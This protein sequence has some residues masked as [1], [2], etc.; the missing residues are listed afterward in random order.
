MHSNFFDLFAMNVPAWQLMLRGSVMYWVLFLMLRF[1]MR[2]EVGGV[3]IADILVLVLLADASQ[4]AMAGEYTTITEGVVLVA[5]IV[6]WNVLFDWLAFHYH[7]FARFVEPPAV[8]LIQN[9]RVLHRNLRREFVT[10]DEL[11]SKLRTRGIED[12]SLVKRASIEGDGEI[13]IVTF[14]RPSQRGAADS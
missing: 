4:N 3:G 10:L 14:D 6:G 2:R 9:G 8:T 13:S 7:A 12:L 1:V 5:T 11:M